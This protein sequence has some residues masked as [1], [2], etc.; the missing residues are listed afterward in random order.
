M[1]RIGADDIERMASSLY[2]DGPLTGRAASRFWVL[3]TL[4][5]VIAASGLVADST[6]TVIGAMIVAPLMT[7]ILG[8]ALAVVLSDRPHLLRSVGLVVGGAATVI[9]IGIVFA[10]IDRPADAFAGNSQVAARISPRLVDLL[11]ALATGMVGA[12]ALVRSD[13]A[14]TLPGVAIAISLVPPLAVVGLLLGVGRV[15]DA[16]QAGL[17]F[18]TNVAA[19]IATGTLVLIAYRVRATAA[20]SGQPLG[21][22][23]G[24]TL[25]AIGLLLVL[26]SI[27]LAFGSA[28]IARD[29]LLAVQARPVA[30]AWA[31]A[32]G[33]EVV[34][35]QATN[36]TVIVSAFGPP[37]EV[38]PASLRRSLNEAGMGANDL[39]IRLVVGGSRQCPAGGSVCD[40]APPI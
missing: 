20:A 6:A 37:P 35:V 8:V 10:L 4:A 22:L 27:P 33:W 31:A 34:D 36:Q 16:L 14:D 15:D 29:E 3:L 2:V 30:T 28:A 11:A 40:T 26:V 19:I 5:A 1:L 13:V 9:A 7:P 24:P 12:F 18:L 38:D 23:S 32:A 17:L 39:L 25:A 21:E